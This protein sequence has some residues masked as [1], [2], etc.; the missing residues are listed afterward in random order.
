MPRTLQYDRTLCGTALALTFFG[1]LM[2]FS[3]T[4]G[5]P[6][7]TMRYVVK[8]LV[9]IGVGLI[10]MRWL[11][12]FDYQHL[13]RQKVMYAVVGAAVVLLTVVLFV[14]ETA[15][16]QRFLNFF[17]LF[18]VQPS[19]LAKLAL[20]VFLASF[21]EKR[22]DRLGNWRTLAGAG[23]IAGAICGLVLVG[24][25][26]GSAFSLAV[27]TCAIFWFAGLKVRYFAA[28]AAIGIPLL[29]LAIWI[30][31]YRIE[32]FFIF[33]DPESDPLGAGFQIIQ[34]KI[35][36]GTGGLFGQGLMESRQKMNFLPEAHT[37]FIF[38]VICEEVGLIGG[39]LVVA[40][41]GVI[42]WRGMAAALNAPDRF[43]CYLAGGLTAMIA[44]QAMLNLGV[45]LAMLP[46]KGM[47]LPF[48]S[49][50]GTA[51]VTVLAA[52]G[53]LLNVSQHRSS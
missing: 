49:Y 47:P 15:N 23:L 19:E 16:T 24:R 37:D 31:D 33:W 25:D 36:V 10:A 35:A 3:A 1:I 40:A 18:S 11:M 14:G 29:A 43:G 13:R 39:L 38:A 4:A 12:Y 20:I 28:A 42:V 53:L 8:Q 27:L 21:L 17:G 34:A 22:S 44:C 32:R 41:F 48:L 51:M 2:V 52:T 9:A 50:G 30:E 5:G 45:V 26:L 46:T 6:M 7:V